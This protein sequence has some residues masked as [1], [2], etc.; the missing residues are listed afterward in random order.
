MN[1]CVTIFIVDLVIDCCPHTS[2][3]KWASYFNFWLFFLPSMNVVFDAPQHQFVW[4]ICWPKATASEMIPI[5]NTKIDIISRKNAATLE[6][7]NVPCVILWFCTSVPL[8]PWRYFF[9]LIVRY[10]LILWNM[11]PNKSQWKFFF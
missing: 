3:W 4:L 11:N 10:T 1:Y 8:L 7:I 5:S 9:I 6:K 2:C